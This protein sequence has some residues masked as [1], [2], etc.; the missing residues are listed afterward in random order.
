VKKAERYFEPFEKN[1]T[2]PKEQQPKKIFEH[3]CKMERTQYQ[4]HVGFNFLGVFFKVL[5]DLCCE[6]PTDQISDANGPDLQ[7]AYRM[8]KVLTQP[9]NQGCDE[10]RNSIREN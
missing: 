1:L 6:K 3:H 7:K 10:H 5:M 9:L 2:E 4:S 8:R